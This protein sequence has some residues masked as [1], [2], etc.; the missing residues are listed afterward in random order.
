M[1]QPDTGRDCWW[2]RDLRSAATVGREAILEL[3]FERRDGR[4]VLARSYVEPPFRIGRCLTLG[5]AAYVII[6]C[7]GPGVF[8]GDALR[9]VVHVGAGARV[10]LASQA[11]L[12]VHPGT[13]AA[14][15]AL[16]ASSP[17]PAIVEQRYTLEE[18]AELHGHWD[19]V[20]PFAGARLAQHIELS[21]PQSARLLWTDGLMA[22][23]VA[24]GEAW[25]FDAISHELRLAVDGRL[26]YLERY[27]IAPCDCAQGGPRD[28]PIARRWIAGAGRYFGTLLVR[29]RAATAAAAEA[30]HQTVQGPDTSAAA[31]LVC[32]RLIAGRI[33]AADGVPFAAARLACR[34]FVLDRVLQSPELACRKSVG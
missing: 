30:L 8:P 27:D 7:S 25:A 33:I 1:H 4:T 15:S 22:G 18:N 19:P 17:G 28:E 21:M 12:Q 6:V 23:R 13:S 16:S 34:R 14:L 32:D 24:R 10:V 5:D 29:D 31:D 11:A 26:R 2:T 20:I 9:Q 3:A